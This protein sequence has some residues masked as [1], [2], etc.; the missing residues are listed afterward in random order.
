MLASADRAVSALCQL[1]L[2][3]GAGASF[4][5]FVLLVGSSFRRYLLGTPIAVT[6]ELAALLFVATSFCS[7]PYGLMAGRH[8]RLQ[9]LG[10]RLPLRLA[11]WASVVGDFL[12]AGVLAIVVI[13]LVA[14]ARYS[15]EVGARTDVSELLLWPWMMVMPSMLGL[16]A[17]ALVLRAVQRGVCAAR[18]QFEL[19]SAESQV[20]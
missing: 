1:S 8:I 2:F 12:G 4:G 14:F 19:P 5:I 10:D 16:V 20:D 18:G 11:A 17:I 3:V 9:V 15:Q 7:I 13:Q 6:E